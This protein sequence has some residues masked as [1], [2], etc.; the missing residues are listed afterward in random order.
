MYDSG[1]GVTIAIGKDNVALGSNSL[2]IGY[3]ASAYNKDAIA[4][5]TNSL[6][7][8]MNWNGELWGPTDKGVGMAIGFGATTNG[9]GTSLGTNAESYG[10]GSIAIG[11]AS[12]VKS[13]AANANATVTNDELKAYYKTYLTTLNFDKLSTGNQLSILTDLRMQYAMKDIQQPMYGVALGSYSRTTADNGVALGA[14]SMANRYGFTSSTTGAYSNTELSG[15]T[16]GAV[17]VGGNGYL[18]QIINLADATQDTDAVNLRQLRAAI[19]SISNGGSDRPATIPIPIPSTPVPTIV[20]DNNVTV[21]YQTGDN[22]SQTVNLSLNPNIHVDSIAINNN[23]PLLNGDGLTMNDKRITNLAD[24]VDPS[25]AVTVRQLNGQMAGI[26]S[27][28][29]TVCG[30]ARRGVALSSALAGLKP[31]SYTDHNQWQIMAA[32][33]NYKGETGFALGVANTPSDDVLLHAGMAFGSGDLAWNAGATF[34]VGQSGNASAGN[35]D[36]VTTKED[37]DKQL[38]AVK[39][40]SDKRYKALEAKMAVLQAKLDAIEQSMIV[41]DSK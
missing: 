12:S 38:A 15:V 31:L 7:L 23:G 14:Y 9:T 28:I 21:D 37:F 41:P 8:P 29:S 5:G 4:I 39:A 27:D 1:E 33:G 13:V 10:Q 17:S 34:R 35:T 40:D 25:D 30:E 26:K 20:G 3:Q 16:L 6:V 24:G 2:T 19:N 22:N 18:R 36:S 32:T 11:F